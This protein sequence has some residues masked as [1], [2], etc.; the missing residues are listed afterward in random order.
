MK[1]D[2][3]IENQTVHLW[4]A[5]LPDL[6]PQENEFLPLLSEDELQRAN[7]F[8]FPKHRQRFIVARGLLR[9][10]LSLYTNV[11]PQE[12]IF[13]Y[14]H[15]GKPFLKNNPL[16]LQFNVSHSDD[17][18]VYALTKEVE[19][20]VDIQKIEDKFNDMVAKRFFSESEYLQ[21]NQV[22][23]DQ[24]IS[25]F[26]Q[27]WSGKEALIKAVGEG[28]YVPLGNFSI[29]LGE[30][31]QWI[32]LTHQQKSENFYLKNF[33]AYSDYQAA[34]ATHQQVENILYW[35]WLNSGPQSWS[36]IDN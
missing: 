18:A 8:K 28:L 35:E 24:R 32:T 26:C 2:F 19:I 13:S 20:G 7:R 1:T 23:E 6:I 3:L 15:R 16:N 14:G 31:P 17:V 22:E 12:I 30:N 21:L 25:A 27:L 9:N 4:R 29:N 11:P 36:Y 10:I 34:F 33:F 5:T